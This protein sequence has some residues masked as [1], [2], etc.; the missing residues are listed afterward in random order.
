M[1][2]AEKVQE[3]ICG[4]ILENTFTSIMDIVNHIFPQLAFVKHLIVRMYWP[5]VDRIPKVRIPLLFVVGTNDE[6]VPP[7]HTGLLYQAAALAPF[8]QMH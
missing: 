6:I 5:T 7:A 3:A 4:V 2:L 8:K 1:Q